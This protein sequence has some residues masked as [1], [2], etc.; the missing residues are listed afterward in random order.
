MASNYDYAASLDDVM[1]NVA[2]RLDDLKQRIILNMGQAGQIVTGRTAASMRVEQVSNNE[3]RLVARPFFSALETGS[4]PWMGRTGERMTAQQFRAVIADWATRKNIVPRGMTVDSFAFVVSRK[5][6]NEGSK[7]YR[8][9][10]RND[11]FTQEVE[12]TEDEI[13]ESVSDTFRVV[14]RDIIG[15]I[16]RFKNTNVWQ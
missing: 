15:N 1:K 7:L 10:G 12:R 8:S 2:I 3:V 14:M 13:R 11:I 4:Q 6:M 9:V 5:I 16:L